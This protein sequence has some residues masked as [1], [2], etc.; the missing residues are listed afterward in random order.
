MIINLEFRS[1]GDTFDI[2]STITAN[3]VLK[4]TTIRV[5]LVLG[6][7]W[8]REEKKSIIWNWSLGR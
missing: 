4:A 2:E 3:K 1:W 7:E 6:S 8:S 5:Y